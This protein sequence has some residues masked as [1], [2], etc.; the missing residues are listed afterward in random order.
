MAKIHCAFE[1]DYAVEFIYLCSPG[2]P[3]VVTGRGTSWLN[4]IAQI[5]TR[6]RHNTVFFSSSFVRQTF[7]L[8]L[9]SVWFTL[10]SNIIILDYIMYITFFNGPFASGRHFSKVLL[11]YT[12]LLSPPQLVCHI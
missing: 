5:A 4:S 12:L 6:F 2:K 7:F 8:L 1:V 11:P 9:L 3:F 10:L